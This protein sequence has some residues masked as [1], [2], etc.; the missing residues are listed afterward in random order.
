MQTGKGIPPEAPPGAKK[1]RGRLYG[2]KNYRCSEHAASRKG[3]PQ[4]FVLPLF[5]SG[6]VEFKG[7]HPGILEG[8]AVG[9]KFSPMLHQPDLFS[10][11]A[12]D[13][14]WFPPHVEPDEDQVRQG[15]PDVILLHGSRAGSSEENISARFWLHIAKQGI[16][17]VFARIELI[18]NHTARASWQAGFAGDIPLGP[19]WSGTHFGLLGFSSLDAYCTARSLVGKKPWPIQATTNSPQLN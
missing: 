10:G 7:V 14:G 17:E 9:E 3:H 18:R 2:F 5:G 13:L 1:E 16:E 15:K 8:K 4:I 12:C 11:F 19:G 6:Q